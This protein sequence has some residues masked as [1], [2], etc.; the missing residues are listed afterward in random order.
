[1]LKVENRLSLRYFR[2]AIETKGKSSKTSFFTLL[3]L[4][5]PIS[6][7]PKFSFLISKKTVNL[8]VDRHSLKR[9]LSQIIQDKLDTFDP[10]LQVIVIPT[11]KSLSLDSHK[12]KEAL[13]Y[14]I[15]LCS[16]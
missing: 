10:H 13:L 12:L 16:L 15:S 3:Y 11:Y 9:K 7:S 5:D 6:L 8:S 14:A 2:K 1:M 4:N